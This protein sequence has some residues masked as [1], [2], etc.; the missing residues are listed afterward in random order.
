MIS[1]SDRRT[2]IELINEATAAGAGKATACREL[3]ISVRTLQR[4]MRTG[5]LT[6]DGRPNA[7]RPAPVNRLS[8]AEQQTI[9]E[10]CNRTEYAS[11]PPG[12]IVPRLADKGVF[13]ASESTFYRVLKANGQLQRRGRAR[14][15]RKVARPTTHVASGPRQVWSWDITY[16][17]STVR[18]QFY[19]LYLIEDIY[20][21]K[22]VGWEVYARESGEHAAA[23][24][25]R[26]VMAEQCFRQPLVLHSDNG[27]PMKSSTLL[28]KLEELGVTPSRSR[29][30]VSN[31]S[32]YSESLFRT[33]KYRPLWPSEGFTDL[34]ETRAWVRRFVDWYN[35]EH[36]HSRIQYVTPAQ[37]HRGED[38]AILRKRQSVYQQ[39]RAQRPERWSGDI[40]DWTPAG[41]VALNP[42]REEMYQET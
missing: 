28:A 34:D 41:N 29:P 38:I 3:G 16:C 14:P 5:Q 27:A 13:L 8:E 10:T 11:L 32:P 30:R 26:T 35:H 19:Y 1:P 22:I 6:E 40:R 7:I 24:M 23:L 2:A 31:D 36:R 20:S 15:P 42:E 4:W 18:G 21:R 9:L 37:R 33:L 39:A 12:Q 25:Q 17:A